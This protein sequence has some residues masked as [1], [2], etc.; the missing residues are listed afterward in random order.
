MLQLPLLSQPSAIGSSI[1]Q[2][3]QLVPEQPGS[4]ATVWVVV[5]ATV[6]ERQ[7][8]VQGRG[9]EP[10]GEHEPEGSARPFICPPAPQS[11]PIRCDC[12]IWLQCTM[13]LRATHVL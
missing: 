6:P 11:D 3:F 8:S 1:T 12:P 9:V 10:V 2:L 5:P 4:P 13:K 7:G